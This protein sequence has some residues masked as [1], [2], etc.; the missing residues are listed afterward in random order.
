MAGEQPERGVKAIRPTREEPASEVLHHDAAFQETID[1][2]ESDKVPHL[3]A[4]DPQVLAIISPIISFV[5]LLVSAI[6]AYY[7]SGA[8]R[9]AEANMYNSLQSSYEAIR[10]RMDSRYRVEAWR[11]SREQ[12]N[13]WVPF[14]EYWFFCLREWLLTK[15]AANRRFASLWDEQ[16]GAAVAAGLGHAP[17]RFVLATMLADGTLDE[18]YTKG[19]IGELIRLHGAD[20]RVEV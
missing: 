17:L 11:P 7:A 15:G 20:F 4:F 8:R 19:F 1:V 9:E 2:G 10:A 3:V 5:S 14:E 18:S 6:A 13:E 12:K 16:I